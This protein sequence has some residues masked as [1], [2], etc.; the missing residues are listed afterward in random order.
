MHSVISYISNT[1]ITLFCLEAIM[2]INNNDAG[3]QRHMSTAKIGPKGQIVIPKDVRD[4]FDLSPGDSV[5][6]L[7]DSKRGIAIERM[8][9]FSKLAD[10]ILEGESNSDNQDSDSERDKIFAGNIKKL[11]K[12]EE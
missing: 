5:V 10:S 3:S 6:I 2:A 9:F 7:A 12:E 1:Y 8:S 4:M 11:E